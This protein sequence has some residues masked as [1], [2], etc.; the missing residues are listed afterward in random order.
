MNL[1]LDQLRRHELDLHVKHFSVRYRRHPRSAAKVC[2]SVV[3]FEGFV[4]F[5]FCR[6]K[7]LKDVLNQ[8]HLSF[9]IWDLRRFLEDVQ[10]VV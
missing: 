1:V 5:N 10:S 8:W 6:A 3:N 7:L 2:E 4:I 9:G